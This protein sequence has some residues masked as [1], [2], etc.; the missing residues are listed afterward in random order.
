[1]LSAANLRWSGPI[2]YGDQTGSRDIKCLYIDIQNRRPDVGGFQTVARLAYITPSNG[3]QVD[4][5]DRSWLKVTGQPGYS[6]VIPPQSHAAF[7]LLGI[8]LDNPSHV[9]LNSALDSLPRQAIITQAGQYTFEYH[10]FSQGF[11]PL[12]FRVRLHVTGCAETVSA[13]LV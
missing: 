9:F 13:Q 3:I 6:Q 1:V 7:D 2:R 5:F 4:C 10:V 12:T 8:S 11:P